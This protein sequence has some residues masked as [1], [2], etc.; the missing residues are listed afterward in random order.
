MALWFG[1]VGQQVSRIASYL[2]MAFLEVR[3]SFSQCGYNY[4]FTSNRISLL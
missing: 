4:N 2:S 1:K 3:R